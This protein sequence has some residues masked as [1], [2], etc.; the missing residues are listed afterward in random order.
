MDSPHNGTLG[1]ITLPAIDPIIDSLDT[2][3]YE[4]H[5]GNENNPESHAANP[6]EISP[7]TAEIRVLQDIFH[8]D[9]HH[10]HKALEMPTGTLSALVFGVIAGVQERA[11]RHGQSDPI[12]PA[13]LPE[14]TAAKQFI[15]TAIAK[16]KVF[17]QP[18]VDAYSRG[19]YKMGMGDRSFV[20][21]T[22]Q[23]VKELDLD[24]KKDFLP[25]GF[26]KHDPQAQ[27]KVLLL[28]RDIHKHF[29]GT[30]RDLLLHNVIDREGKHMRTSNKEVEEKTTPLLRGRLAHLRI[31]TIDT[32]I[33]HD[34]LKKSQ[35]DTIDNQIHQLKAL[36]ADYR[37]AHM[38]AL[39]QKDHA[40]FGQDKALFD[41]DKSAIVMPTEAEVR[42]LIA[43]KQSTSAA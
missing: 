29:R 36:G 18:N 40:L 28:V 32:L 20:Y 9:N 26:V 42:A 1:D 21:L 43:P 38:K 25:P 3:F 27:S 19:R 17:L 41:V 31:Q 4:A 7:S 5:Q 12:G 13:G 14:S 10:L 11:L 30:I 24:F 8:L 39:L 16:A 35:W 15:F 6:L 33:H 2:S 34:G 23:G 37:A 22:I